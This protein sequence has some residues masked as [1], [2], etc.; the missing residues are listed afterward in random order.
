VFLPA[1]VKDV[2]EFFDLFGVEELRALVKKRSAAESR[3]QTKILD[4]TKEPPPVPWLVEDLLALGDVTMEIGDPNVGKSWLSM[5]LAVK[6][7]NA[8]EP[9]Y[10]LGHALKK[11]GK[12]LY[13]DEENPLDVVYHRLKRLGLTSQ[14]ARNIRYLFQPGIWLNKDPAT[15]LEEALEFEPVLIVLDS[16]ARIHTADEN[17]AS[18]MAQLFKE[19]I[20]PLARETGAAVL[21][22]H[23]TTK[24]DGSSFQR[25]RG[26]GD[27]TASPDA[28][29][30]VRSTSIPGMLTVSNYKSRRRLTGELIS[31]RIEDGPADTVRL[32]VAPSSSSVF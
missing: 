14:G 8:E 16:M 26:S 9:A 23:H 12:V 19:A 1:G 32:S 5:D 21:L 22:L 10:W 6:I 30:D 15:L 29:L 31:L 20:K 18:A 17:S 4:L 11:F 24:G 27:I 2:C 28:G 7:A 25:S 3:F 13:V